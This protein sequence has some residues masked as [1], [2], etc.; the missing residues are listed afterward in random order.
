M[1]ALAVG[2]DFGILEFDGKRSYLGFGKTLGR[3][4]IV[5]NAMSCGG[6][7]VW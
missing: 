1:S 2:R 4:H 6:V 5:E 7:R 3:G